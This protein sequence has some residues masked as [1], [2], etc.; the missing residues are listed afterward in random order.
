[1]I[2]RAFMP[3]TV[4]QKDRYPKIPDTSSGL[5]WLAGEPARQWDHDDRDNP[6][7]R[8]EWRP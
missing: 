7:Y 3:H 8:R 6:S 5:R 4:C 2:R 1:M